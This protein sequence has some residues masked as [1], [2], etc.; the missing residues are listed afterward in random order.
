MSALSTELL[1]DESKIWG[2]N[3]PELDDCALDAAVEDTDEAGA[4][5]GVTWTSNVDG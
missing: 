4:G 1:L 3:A 5:V 2:W